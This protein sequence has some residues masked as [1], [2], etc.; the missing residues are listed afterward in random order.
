MRHQPTR[1]LHRDVHSL[2][3][4]PNAPSHFCAIN[5][6]TGASSEAPPPPSWLAGL[7]VLGSTTCLRGVWLVEDLWRTCIVAIVAWENWRVQCNV[8]D[9]RG[10][11]SHGIVQVCVWDELKSCWGVSCGTRR[12]SGS[13]RRSDVSPALVEREKERELDLCW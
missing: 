13:P 10:M 9:V 3:V 1:S 12:R 5:V 6:R 8:S 7:S 2:L 11:L 4:L